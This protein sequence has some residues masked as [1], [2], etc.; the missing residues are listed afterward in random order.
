LAPD[1]V[2]KK[3]RGLLWPMFL[4]GL[5]PALRDWWLPR[6]VNAFWRE[7]SLAPL[8]GPTAGAPLLRRRQRFV[9]GSCGDCR[10]NT[11]MIIYTI[12]NI[13]CDE[14]RLINTDLFLVYR[15][16]SLY[17][18]VHYMILMFG[19]PTFILCVKSVWDLKR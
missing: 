3:L 7:V 10:I 6:L 15:R 19:S 2:L 5:D 1:L 11:T 4:I 18:V 9:L 8:S 13:G 17:A 14:V 12:Q 16:I